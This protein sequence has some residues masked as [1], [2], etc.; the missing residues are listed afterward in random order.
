MSFRVRAVF[1]VVD[2]QSTKGYFLAKVPEWHADQLVQI[3]LHDI[4]P[5]ARVLLYE[6]K[7]IT[8]EIDFAATS[9]ADLH[10]RYWDIR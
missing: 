7:R 5:F 10:P 6:G 4:T 1:Q 3:D 2:V 8:A 9:A